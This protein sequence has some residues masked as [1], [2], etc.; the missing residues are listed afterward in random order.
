MSS[1]GDVLTSVVANCRKNNLSLS[2][3]V[4][5][6]MSCNLTSTDES[7]DD[8]DPDVD[9]DVDVELPEEVE[10]CGVGAKSYSFSASSPLVSAVVGEMSSCSKRAD[11]E[12]LELELLDLLMSISLRAR[13]NGSTPAWDRWM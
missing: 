5:E 10:F 11:E 6:M 13:T 12:A 2:L 9:P 1:D 3:S 7:P 8:V 4:S